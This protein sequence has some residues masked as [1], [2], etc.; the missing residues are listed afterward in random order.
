MYYFPPHPRFQIR[1]GSFYTFANFQRADRASED[2]PAPAPSA[3]S[4]ILS[5]D[6]TEYEGCHWLPHNSSYYLLKV[7]EW[8]IATVIFSR[9]SAD[10]IP[11]RT[12][13]KGK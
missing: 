13:S 9:T 4:I 2:C 11:T 10:T 8:V 6:V 1:T 5:R 3:Q 7:Y 12:K